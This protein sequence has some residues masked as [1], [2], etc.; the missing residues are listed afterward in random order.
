MYIYI[1][2]IFLTIFIFPNLTNAQVN[3]YI[4]PEKFDLK[5]LPGESLD[6]KI[7]I[8]NLGQESLPISIQLK[9]FSANGEK[10]GII[11]EEGGD[12]SFDPSQ[13]IKFKEKNF[14]LKSQDFKELNFTI[15]I[16]DQ[17]E[18]G[19]YYA[20]A[21]FQTEISPTETKSSTKILPILGALFLLTIEGGEQKYPSLDKQIEVVELKVPSFIENG[22][23][24]VNFRVKNN[25]PIHVGISG[26]LIIYDLFGRIKEEI[27]VQPTTIL[28]G[29]IRFFELK[30][31][32]NKFFDNFFLGPYQAK[33]ILSTKTWQEK[34]GNN[35]QLIKK[36][37]FFAFPWKIFVIFIITILILILL[38]SISK[39]K[40]KKQL[41]NQLPITTT[42]G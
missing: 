14:I 23:M 11:F 12:I 38:V 34:I 3:F 9:N 4:S 24:T 32:E 41:N 13:W 6:K 7:I 29:K 35:Q 18:P 19:G 21:L 10:G 15:K 36:F 5:L 33:L 26:K 1:I 17:A 16:P 31:K 30:T 22:P 2:I 25:D 37:Q 8:S 20:S 42:V 27:E 40:K 39:R 28:P